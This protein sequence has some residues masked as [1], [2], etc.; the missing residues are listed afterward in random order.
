MGKQKNQRCYLYLRVSTDI[1]VEGYSLDA[2]R[3][4]LLREADYRN[5]QMVEEFRDEG[6]SGKNTTGRP[7]F[8]E[9]MDRIQNG[10]PDGVDYVLVFKLSRFGRNTTVPLSLVWHAAA[11]IR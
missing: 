10:N 7:A 11:I 4:R 6:K 5:M 8:L 3:E 2:Q 1:Q 9:M